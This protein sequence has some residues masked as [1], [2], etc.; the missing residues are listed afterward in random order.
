MVDPDPKSTQAA[1]AA[2]CTKL[3]LHDRLQALV[4][5]LNTYAGNM[6][7]L[8]AVAFHRALGD[9]VSTLGGSS[10]VSIG[11]AIA[12]RLEHAE[13][14]MTSAVTSFTNLA[15]RTTALESQVQQLTAQLAAL[16]PAPAAAPAAAPAPAPR[17]SFLPTGAPLTPAAA[18]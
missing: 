2:L 9:V 5:S 16:Q 15:G 4:N 10:D 17:P 12:A 13:N 7:D 18:G 14:W 8:A 1:A 3:S 6:G 11:A